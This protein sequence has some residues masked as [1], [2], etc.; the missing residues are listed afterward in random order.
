[1][2]I[3]P[4]IRVVTQ[5]QANDARGDREDGGLRREVLVGRVGVGGCVG[6]QETCDRGEQELSTKLLLDTENRLGVELPL[7]EVVALEQLVELLDLPTQVVDLAH[8]RPSD[9]AATQ[10]REQDPR[11]IG[12]DVDAHSPQLERRDFDGKSL[13]DRDVVC[14]VVSV[15]D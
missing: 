11:I 2:M 6:H 15:V 1:M 12:A 8:E 13:A 10:G 9:F 7:G 5:D 4:L 14:R 3:E